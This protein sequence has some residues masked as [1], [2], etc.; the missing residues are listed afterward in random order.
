MDI[1]VDT[2]GNV[3]VVS[4][5]GELDGH[6]SPPAQDRILPLIQ[7]G[8]RVLLNLTDLEYMSSAGARMLLLIYRQI[9]AN[10]GD[11]ILAGLIPEIQD[12]LVSTGFLGYFEIAATVDDGLAMFG[13]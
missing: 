3:T 1:Y 5:V 7:P 12:M 8:T 13:E 9:K 10:N 6:T 2:V 11:V 4:I